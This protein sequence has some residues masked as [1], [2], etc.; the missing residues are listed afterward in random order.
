MICYIIYSFRYAAAKQIPHRKLNNKNGDIQEVMDEKESVQN[1]NEDLV[2]KLRLQNK[3]LKDKIGL[4]KEKIDEKDETIS[5][6]K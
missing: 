1:N 5:K 6:I 4:L 3:K 2:I